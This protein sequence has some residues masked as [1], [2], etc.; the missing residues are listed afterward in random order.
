ME[1]LFLTA[2]SQGDLDTAHR[3]KVDHNAVITAADS[4]GRNGAHL[5]V[6]NGQW[7]TAYY[8]IK[9]FKVSPHK[10]TITGDNLYHTIIRRCAEAPPSAADFARI[11]S[12]KETLWRAEEASSFNKHAGVEFPQ[13]L[14]TPIEAKSRDYFE[15]PA[16]TLPLILLKNY[17]LSIKEVNNA[18]QTPLALAISLNL[19][20]LAS[21]FEHHSQATQERR[22]LIEGLNMNLFRQVV[23]LL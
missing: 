21:F 6:L 17:H 5:A 22:R 15:N 7:Q 18:G 16:F 14:H 8:L 12:E 3:L 23:L 2:C 13:T 9:D 10:R 20:E 1:D 11:Q 19:G 4:E